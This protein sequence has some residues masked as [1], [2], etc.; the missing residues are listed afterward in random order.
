MAKPSAAS[1][2][3]LRQIIATLQTLPAFS[4]MQSVAHIFHTV[5]WGVLQ[6]DQLGSRD[7]AERVCNRAT[8]LGA[9]PSAHASLV[10]LK[11]LRLVVFDFQVVTNVPE[12]RQLHP[13]SLNTAASGH[14]VTLARS[15]HRRFDS[16]N[17]RYNNINIIN[18]H[19]THSSWH[20]G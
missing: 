5:I 3:K 19:R 7:T 9:V 14:A 17:G 13:A 6:V 8:V 18:C 20:S 4:S 16:L 2:F 12:V 11:L 10:Q 15:L 1:L